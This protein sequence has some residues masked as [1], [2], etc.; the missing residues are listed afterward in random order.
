MLEDTLLI[1]KKNL[2]ELDEYKTD[3]IKLI[4]LGVRGDLKLAVMNAQNSKFQFLS[5]GQLQKIY[6]AHPER[7][8]I[9]LIEGK[10]NSSTRRFHKTPYD[11]KINLSD[12]WVER[13]KSK[14]ILNTIKDKTHDEGQKEEISLETSPY[15]N[16]LKKLTEQALSSY[17]AWKDSQKEHQRPIQKSGNL[18]E[19]LINT[20]GAA[21][22][23]AE[24]IKKILSDFHEE[25]N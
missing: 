3:T 7:V 16:S 24:I 8:F 10:Y 21:S 18:H 22:R 19:W 1:D 20:I 15:W 14:K 12:L 5:P 25:L 4:Q 13:S 23:E 2:V 9:R 6:S 11:Q 17:P